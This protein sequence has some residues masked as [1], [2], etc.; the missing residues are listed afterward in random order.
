MASRR[1]R[2][3]AED[4]DGVKVIRFADAILDQEDRSVIEDEVFSLVEGTDQK[5]LRLDLTDVTFVSSAALGALIALHRKLRGVGGQLSL[6]NL[7]PEM[8]EVIRATR[9]DSVL[10]IQS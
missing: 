6:C 10:D 8:R 4:V 3:V 2:F 7:N 1:R 9:L 5:K